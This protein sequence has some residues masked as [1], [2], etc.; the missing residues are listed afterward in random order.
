MPICFSDEGTSGGLCHNSSLKRTNSVNPDISRLHFRSGGN[1]DGHLCG[2]FQ[3]VIET[4]DSSIP[5]TILSLDNECGNNGGRAI[6]LGAH[7]FRGGG[8]DDVFWQLRMVENSR[9]IN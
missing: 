7:Y 4:I 5:S 8:I 9:W 6:S 1:F 3:R 2:G